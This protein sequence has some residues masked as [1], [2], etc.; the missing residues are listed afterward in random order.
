[1][2]VSSSEGRVPERRWI[3]ALPQRGQRRER[4]KSYYINPPTPNPTIATHHRPQPRLPRQLGIMPP[5][6][7]PGTPH[8]PIEL[9]DWRIAYMPPHRE[10]HTAARPQRPWRGDTDDIDI[11]HMA[12]R[13]EERAGLFARM[14]RAVG[15]WCAEETHGE[16]RWL[17]DGKGEGA[18]RTGAWRDFRCGSAWLSKMSSHM[19]RVSRRFAGIYTNT[20][21][22]DTLSPTPSISLSY[23]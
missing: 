3:F 8:H 5:S 16:M 21:P 15:G 22:S 14:G 17:G 2:R 12:M 23:R 4:P 7:R 11:A 20:T 13:K 19:A 10:G 18:K 9:A 1:M 6:R